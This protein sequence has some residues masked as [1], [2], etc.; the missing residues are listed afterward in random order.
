[1][2]KP[3]DSSRTTQAATPLEQLVRWRRDVRRFRIDAV[4][5][6]ILDRILNLADLSPS[7]G[8]S[9]PWRVL[10]VTDTQQRL[11]VRANFETARS[12]AGTMYDGDKAQ[13]Y[14]SLKLAGFDAAPVHLAV[15]CDHGSKQGHGLGQQTMPEALE[16]SCACMITVLW[17]AAREA[18]LGLGWVSILDPA[19]VCKTLNVSSAWKFAG[20]LLIGWP[21]EEH[22]DPELERHGWQGRTPFEDRF[23][24][25]ANTAA[26]E[27]IDAA[28]SC[29]VSRGSVTLVGAGPG[30]PD[31]LTVRALRALQS[32]DAIL[33][34]DLVAKPILE[35]ARKDARIIDVGKRGYRTSCKQP[36]INAQLVDLAR[37]GL[38]V[39]RLKSGDPLIFGRAGEEITACREAGIPIDVVPG[40]T[41][42]QGAAARLGV[43]LTHRDHARR[44]Q[45]ITAHDRHGQLPPDIDW[46]AVADA[47]ATTVIYMPKRTLPELTAIAMAHGLDP[48]TPALAVANATRADE[49][50]LKSTVQNIAAKL[51]EASV[52]G[53]VLVMIGEALRDAASGSAANT[54][55]AASSA[56][57]S[58]IDPS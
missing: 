12:A 10:K 17:L 36:D 26:V 3:E 41:S 9:Q 48:E 1:M 15:F 33:F 16:Q 45:F 44:L 50:V 51:Q 24:A 32:A 40:I 8:N 38:K 57:L 4:P 58:L 30:D 56:V 14:A 28:P 47:A 49:W 19:A 52:D 25:A 21:E 23:L 7:V 43:S 27:R 46:S 42:A 5:D 18:G 37:Q 35:L 22:L 53:P 29:A 31:L 54:A 39:V 55:E 2:S 6:T 20:Y 34:D 13:L 11:A